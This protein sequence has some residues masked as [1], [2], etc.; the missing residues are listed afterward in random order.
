MKKIISFGAIAIVS[1][2][3]IATLVMGIYNTATGHYAFR[4]GGSAQHQGWNAA[5]GAGRGQGQGRRWT[6]NRALSKNQQDTDSLQ[7]IEPI[8]GSNGRGQGQQGGD[9][10]RA[11]SDGW[12]VYEGTLTELQP[13][14]VLQTGDGQSIQLGMGPGSYRES[15]EL[16]LN[17]GDEVSVIGF[18][19][20]SEFKV[21]D[22][23]NRATGQRAVFR[24]DTGRPMWAGQ[25]RRR[26]T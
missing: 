19:E 21:K 22:L 17:V 23:A 15:L 16:V 5:D 25:G 9:V 2:A 10:V 20:G 6:E 18:Y 1:L 26:N 7:V 8:S 4:A 11:E 14:P 24:D 13:E 3:V 12:V